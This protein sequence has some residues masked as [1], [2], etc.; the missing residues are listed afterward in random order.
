M[1]LVTTDDIPGR[2]VV[3]VHLGDDP[4]RALEEITEAIAS[5]RV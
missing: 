5:A 2:R 1:I 3:R 4:E